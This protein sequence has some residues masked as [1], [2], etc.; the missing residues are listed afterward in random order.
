M[1]SLFFMSMIAA[2]GAEMIRDMLRAAQLSDDL[3]ESDERFRKVAETVGEF[4]WEVDWNGRVVK[5]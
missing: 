5:K 3:R 1:T 4:I 2:M